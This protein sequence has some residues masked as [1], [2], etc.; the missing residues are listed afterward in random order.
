MV[1]FLCSYTWGPV[2]SGGAQWS[3]V[4]PGEVRWGLVRPAA[5][6]KPWNAWG[7]F[8]ICGTRTCSPI[9]CTSLITSF[10]LDP[11]VIVFV[12]LFSQASDSFKTEKHDEIL[13]GA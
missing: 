1:S 3:L 9:V 6:D 7:I 8:A 5:Q 12:L 10:I 13:V 2:G 11:L 4:G